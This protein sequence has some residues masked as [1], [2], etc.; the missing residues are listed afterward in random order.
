MPRQCPLEAVAKGLRTVP[1]TSWD[2]YKDLLNK[3]GGGNLPAMKLG[4]GTPN[5]LPIFLLLS[6]KFLFLIDEKVLL[7]YL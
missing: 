6:K 1:G 3:R 2:L 5:I 7:S 4:E